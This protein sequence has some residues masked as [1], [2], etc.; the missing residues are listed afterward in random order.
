MTHRQRMVESREQLKDWLGKRLG[1]DQG[2]EELW[3]QLERDHV[4]SEFVQGY[5]DKNDVLVKA[6]EKIREARELSHALGDVGRAPQPQSSRKEPG[7]SLQEEYFE[8][9][10]GDYEHKRARAY[11]EVLAREAGFTQQIADFRRNLL[12]ERLLTQ[13][14]AHEL[15]ESP[16]ARFFQPALFERWQIPLT[17]HKAELLEYESG[18]DER[19][20]DHRATIHLEPPGVT[21]TVRY[22][23]DDS[24]EIDGK[25]IDW[26]WYIPL[27]PEGSMSIPPERRVLRYRDRDGLKE[28]MWVWPGSVLD[29]LRGI[30]TRW[31]GR[32]GWR[33]EDMTLWLL[34]GRPPK[35]DPLTAKVAYKRGSPLTVELTVHPWVPAETVL[36]N[37]RKIQRQL[38]GKENHRLKS[39]SLEVVRFVENRIRQEEGVRPPWRKLLERWNEEHLAEERF[40]DLR[41]FARVY[42]DTSERVAHYS[43][44]PPRRKP[45]SP[46]AK[47]KRDKKVAE[48]EAFKHR[49]STALEAHV[50]KHGNRW[51]E[52]G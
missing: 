34:C 9:E 35:F 30:S 39:R 20:I 46:A 17:G 12:G 6:K 14:Q 25:T 43:F 13:E 40:S 16:A 10:L 21:K 19:K 5:Y 45:L 38:L 26:H 22:A 29:A 49:V 7:R 28:E 27:D 31:A 48:A 4:V 50:E 23:N 36:E 18:Q 47:R 44:D 8:V 3:Q 1:I 37:Y 42:K 41:N 33:D 51:P 15:L 2:M 11:E 32:L 52:E 24:A